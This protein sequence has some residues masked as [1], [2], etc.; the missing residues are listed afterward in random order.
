MWKRLLGC[1]TNGSRD[2]RYVLFSRRRFGKHLTARACGQQL[3]LVDVADL[4][5]AG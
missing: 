2:R 1:R 4:Y 3:V 5:A